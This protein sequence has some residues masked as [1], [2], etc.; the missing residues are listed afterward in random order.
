MTLFRS[1]SVKDGP[2]KARLTVLVLAGEAISA[3]TLGGAA[4]IAFAADGGSGGQTRALGK[5][6]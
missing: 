5:R 3:L 4:D 1:P 2:V 6:L